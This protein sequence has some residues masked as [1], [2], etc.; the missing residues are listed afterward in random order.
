MGLLDKIGD[1]VK[2]PKIEKGEAAGLGAAAL[3][4]PPVAIGYGAL[5]AGQGIFNATKNPAK[6]IKARKEMLAADLNTLQ[7]D[8]NKLG[9]SDAEREQMIGEAT[10][11]ARAAQQGQVSQLS[12]DALATQGGFQS[13]AFTEAQRAVSDQGQQAAAQAAVAVNQLHKQL[14]Q[15]EK[16]RILGEVN[17]A[18][19][20][21]KENQRYWTQ[22][23]VQSVGSII[24]AAMGVPTSPLAGA[25]PGSASP[26]PAG[27][28]P[29]AQSASSQGVFVD[30]EALAAAGQVA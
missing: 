4:A 30:P 22:F 19:D 20:R 7:T 1:V 29:G 25:P 8:P 11:A 14:V 18:A 3:F 10:Q 24:A 13:G 28:T 15:Q 17:A 9:I 12:R 2:S 21:A 26:P 16:E 6:P 5:K 27:A 23:G